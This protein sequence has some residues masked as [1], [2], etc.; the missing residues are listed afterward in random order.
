MK[1]DIATAYNQYKFLGQEFLL[2]LWYVSEKDPGSINGILEKDQSLEITFG[3][4]IVIENEKVGGAKEKLTIKGEDAGLEEAL[5]ALNKGGDTVQANF[6]FKLD[7]MDF[8]FTI[9]GEDLSLKGLKFKVETS[10]K[11]KEEIEAAILEKMYLNKM[12]FSCLDSLYAFFVES[13][14]TGDWETK[15]V[16]GIK[17]WVSTGQ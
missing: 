16:P 11:G 6:I 1:L 17:N 9:K 5:M 10:N 8:N 13:R 15:I 4:N 14:L 2:W 3:N 7:D 12:L